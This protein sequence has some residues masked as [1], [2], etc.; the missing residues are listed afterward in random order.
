MAVTRGLTARPGHHHQENPLRSGK[1]RT[2]V[3]ITFGNWLSRAYLGLAGFLLLIGAGDD[4][5]QTAGLWALL[6][7]VPTGAALIAMVNAAGEWAPE[8]DAVVW[9]ILLF[10]YLFQAFLLG[11]AA[12][13]VRQAAE[14]F[15]RRPA[16]APQ[17]ENLPEET[18]GKS[19]ES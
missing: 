13:A 2:I 18:S 6:L 14:R 5:S 10:S 12:R 1:L 8:S 15:G 3:G 16:T 11:L 4:G 19:V 9:F 7:A 17:W